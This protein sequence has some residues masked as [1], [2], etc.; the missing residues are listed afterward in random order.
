MREI[1]AEEETLL[2]T[3]DGS[4]LRLRGREN[5]SIRAGLLKPR[6]NYSLEVRDADKT[7]NLLNEQNNSI[8]IH[9]CLCNHRAYRI[10]SYMCL[11]IESV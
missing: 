6:G 9:M 1:N 3:D 10:L 7:F 4:K 8:D 2:I 5:R 11:L